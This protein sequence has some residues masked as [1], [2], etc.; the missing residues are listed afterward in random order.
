MLPA[1]DEGGLYGS[2]EKYRE[3]IRENLDMVRIQAELGSVHASVGDDAGLAY[4]L[5][6][7]S[8]YLK[9]ALSTYADLD[10]LKRERERL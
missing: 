4:A 8:A 10:A 1:N 7:L 2:L 6:R 5:R 9:A 3:F